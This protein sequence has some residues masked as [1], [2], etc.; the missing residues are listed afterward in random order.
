MEPEGE[1]SGVSFMGQ[2]LPVGLQDCVRDPR[3]PVD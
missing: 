1:T 3:E 2:P